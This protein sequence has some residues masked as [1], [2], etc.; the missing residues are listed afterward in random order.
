MAMGIPTARPIIRPVS[1]DSVL[2]VLLVTPLVTT[3][4]EVMVKAPP[5]DPL[6]DAAAATLAVAAVADVAVPEVVD[7]FP[8]ATTEP[9]AMEVKV[10]ASTWV[11][12]IFM[13][14]SSQATRISMLLRTYAVVVAL[15][16]RLK[17]TL[18]LLWHFQF[19]LVYP[20]TQEVQ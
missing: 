8:E 20:S 12:S 14:V 7:P 15:R 19:C 10:M 13:A 2:S 1:S 9:R 6:D 16:V 11:G 18:M 17:P 4:D 5:I 3:E